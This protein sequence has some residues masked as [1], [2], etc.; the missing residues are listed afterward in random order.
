LK[1]YKDIT[2]P[3]V[4]KALAHPLR[5]RILIALEGRTASPSE[6]AGEL[7]ASLGIVSYHVRRLSALGFVKLV[8]KV[9]R[10]GAIEHYYTAISHPLISDA[11]WAS[12]P[13]VVKQATVAPRLEQIG[14][15]AYAALVDGGF[16]ATE[17]HL[18]RTPVTVD[19]LGW[20]QL[21][22]K[23]ELLIGEIQT[24]ETQSEERLAR[25]NHD[26]EQ[27][28]SVV[29]MLFHRPAVPAPAT[30]PSTANASK[31]KQRSRG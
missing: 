18:T 1:P 21:A 31:R 10:R 30:A 25:A 6:L 29:L 24:I 26:G 7:G 20:R 8:K 5:T 13:S 14:S 19:E 9:P 22:G 4:A 28:I 3:A 12:T 17:T 23:L 27:D 16:D 11:A 2:D 15:E